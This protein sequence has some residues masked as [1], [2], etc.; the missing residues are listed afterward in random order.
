MAFLKYLG[1]IMEKFRQSLEKVW[2]NFGISF[3][4]IRY[5][6]G[7]IYLNLVGKI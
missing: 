2:K 1:D 3:G 6:F 5:S 7:K 4:M